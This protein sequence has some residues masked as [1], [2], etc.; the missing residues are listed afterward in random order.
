MNDQQAVQKEI[1][2]FLRKSGKIKPTELKNEFQLLYD[3]I[4]VYKED[5]HERRPF[6][7]LD[8]LSWLQSKI[9]NRPVQEIMQEK[10]STL[11]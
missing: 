7:Y 10:F 4:S 3:R 6:L 11:K 9:K 8:I 2:Q 1:F 5:I